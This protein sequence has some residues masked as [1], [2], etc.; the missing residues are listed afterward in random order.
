MCHQWCREV[1]C[2][3][4][5]CTP[6]NNPY[7]GSNPQWFKPNNYCNKSW[8]ENK[9]H[10]TASDP[11]VFSETS[12]SLGK[13]LVKLWNHICVIEKCQYFKPCN[14]N[15]LFSSKF[16]FGMS[17]VLGPRWIQKETRNTSGNFEAS[18]KQHVKIQW[19]F[20]AMSWTCNKNLWFM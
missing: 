10:P 3:T 2:N 7:T 9:I 4:I 16:C 18:A 11:G 19:V 20:H 6:Q 14:I 13:D 5:S 12:L 15:N 1:T 17:R 8:D